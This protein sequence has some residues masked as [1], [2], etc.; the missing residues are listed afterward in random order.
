MTPRVI[1]YSDEYREN[2]PDLFR[3]SDNL[4]L[5]FESIFSTCD[6][7]QEEFLWL[8]QNILNLDI[9]EG[10][11]L[12]LIGKIVGQDRLLID[13]DSEIAFGFDKAYKSETFGSLTDPAIGG[14]WKSRGDF[15][16][17]SSRL[18]NDSE[19]RRVIRARTVYNN[20]NCTSSELLEVINLLTDRTDNLL[21]TLSHGNISVTSKD[22]SGFLSY[23]VDKINTTQSILPVAAGVQL[24]LTTQEE[25]I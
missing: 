21:Q 2:R 5:L 3:E 13:F 15:D 18:M 14:K 4:T 25:Q 1:N 10:F 19:Y 8:S 22:T 23:F 11:H 24:T 7:Q 9:A 17:L 16:K 6:K 20:S 12:D